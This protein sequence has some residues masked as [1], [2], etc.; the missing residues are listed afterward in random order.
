[1]GLS[2]MYLRDTNLAIVV[3]DVAKRE[4]LEKAE[5]WIQ[6]L[7]SSGPSEILIALAGNKME[8]Q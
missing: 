8:V 1:M 5:M 2:R 6:E 4:S 3:Y 7:R